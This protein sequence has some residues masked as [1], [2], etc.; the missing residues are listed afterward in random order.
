MML[1]HLAAWWLVQAPV[2][3]VGAATPDP[4]V[5]ATSN[6]REWRLGGALRLR[7]FDYLIWQ[8]TQDVRARWGLTLQPIFVAEAELLRPSWIPLTLSLASAP[9]LQSGVP[10]TAAARLLLRLPGTAAR[11]GVAQGFVGG[12]TSAP[13]GS[14]GSARS[15]PGGRQL[16]FSMPF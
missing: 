15:M 2:P 13:L 11:I 8:P 14:V 16:S 10:G 6:L 1:V 7:R 3:M 12:F 4:P 5:L 9:A